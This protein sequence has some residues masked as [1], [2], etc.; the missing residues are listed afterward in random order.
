MNSKWKLGVTDLKTVCPDIAGEWDYEA[1]EKK[2]EDYF[3]KSLER[4]SWVC[5]ECGNKWT[6][7]IRYRTDRGSGCPECA[8]ISRGKKKHLAAL[9]T[10]GGIKNALLLK[11]WDHEK[12]NSGPE[13]YTEGSNKYVHWIC[14]VCGHEY[15]AKIGN[16]TFLGRGCPCC[17]NTVVVE[18]K[19]DLVTTHPQISAEWDYEKNGNLLPTKVTYGQ[20]KKVWWI[21]PEGHSYPATIL[22]RT[23]GNTNCPICNSGRQTSFAEQAIFFYVKKVFSDAT[24]R[25][26][27]I[28][29]NKMELDVY[30]PS[31]SL[32]IEY[33]G[34]AW[35]KA[36]NTEREKRKYE[37]CRQKGIKL[38]RL[39]ESIQEGAR[40]TADQIISTDKM[41]EHKNLE[42]VIRLLVDSID[43]KSNMWTRKYACDFHSSVDINIA[44]DEQEIRQ[45]MTALKKNSLAESF[46][47]IA[48]EWHPTKNGTLTPNMFLP[49]S[50]IKVH[51]LCSTCGYEYQST[52]AHRTYGTGCPKCGI[53]K[54]AKARSKAIEMIDAVTNEVIKQFE[55]I[56]SAGRETGINPANITSV[57][58]GQ[59][60]K[61]GGYKWRFL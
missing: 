41:Y 19:N 9:E 10:R 45:Y 26:T 30:I 49:R 42:K 8:K 52:I 25:N 38:I 59:R 35:H 2:P 56:A 61:A 22:H 43:P 54:S 28:L 29:G 53:K 39:K 24:S 36:E 4:V 58:N 37:M 17:A 60:N 14:S 51:W 27:D 12:N 5:R 16:R 18:G 11:E 47:E 31:I 13:N 15:R 33:D 1:N 40:D 20:G 7:K 44:R 55:S 21:C 34:M 46:P 23:T 32:A 3:Y 50:D 6:T 57:C 48:K